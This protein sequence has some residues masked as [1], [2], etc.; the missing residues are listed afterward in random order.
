MIGKLLVI[1]PVGGVGG[2]L[3]LEHLSKIVFQLLML[4]MLLLLLMLRIEKKS[5][6]RKYMM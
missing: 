4:L 6:A 5:S 1:L 2:R 3:A